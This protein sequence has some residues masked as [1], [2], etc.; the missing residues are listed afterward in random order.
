M[1]VM[2]LLYTYHHKN[3]VHIMPNTH[4]A[5]SSIMYKLTLLPQTCVLYVFCSLYLQTNVKLG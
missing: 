4:H 3:V 2:N 1:H 5:F